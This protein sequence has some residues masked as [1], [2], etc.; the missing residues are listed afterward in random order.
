VA[1]DKD[2]FRVV[3]TK[4]QAIYFGTAAKPEDDPYSEAYPD[5]VVTLYGPDGQ[6][7]ARNDDSLGSN[8]SE[9]LYQVPA[10]GTYCLEVA[11]CSV[12]YGE[13]NCYPLDAITNT[14]YNVYAFELDPAG[15]IATVDKEPNDNPD[16]KTPMKVASID[17]NGMKIGYQSL[18]WGA[19]ASGTDK[20]FYAL[21][22]AT[23]FVIEP[24]SRG[25]C[26][27]NFFE[28]G[29]EGSGS[30]AE[31]A[32]MAS[33]STMANPATK[34]AEVDITSL[35]VSLG[36]PEPASISFPCTPGTD[37]LFSLSRGQGAVAGVHDTY[38][39]SHVQFGSDRVEVE[40]NDKNAETL[41]I[42]T[43]QDGSVAGASFTGDIAQAGVNGD[44]DTFV[45]TVPPGMSLASVFCYAQ[46]HGSGLRGLRATLLGANDM[47]LL[48]GSGTEGPDKA[49]WIDSAS[50][51]SGATSIKVK[52][53]ADSQDPAVTGKYYSCSLV[54]SN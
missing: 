11:N 10:D 35:D 13:D 3:L 37:Y 33:I 47:P 44:A 49:L 52:I 15:A 43:S 22:P 41:T 53:T 20:D 4:G 8:N 48:K 9:L 39:F 18:G 12:I 21:K 24:G 46:R 7:I 29:I 45:A 2:Y 40:P 38:F 1:D 50:I 31:S 34:I 17:Q 51:P 42:N 30:T 23:D 19:F 26:V 28:A 16:Q 6:Q 27:F 32:V 54:L 36:A 25:Q 14:E 5:T